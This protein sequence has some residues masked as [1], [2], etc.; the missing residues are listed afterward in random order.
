MS[1]GGIKTYHLIHLDFRTDEYFIFQYQKDRRLTAN[2]AWKFIRQDK[3][4]SV[5]KL[6]SKATIDTYYNIIEEKAFNIK[7]CD[8]YT[9]FKGFCN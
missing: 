7:Y 4:V 9:T 6:S 3:P 1:F 2:Q 5:G 8:R